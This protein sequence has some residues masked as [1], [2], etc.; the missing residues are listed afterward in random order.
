M[1]KIP[2]SRWQQATLA[3]KLIRDPR[4]PI[5]TKLAVPTAVAAYVIS[6]VDLIP[7]MLVGIGQVDDFTL[8]LLAIPAVSWFLRRFAPEVI[9]D[10]Y[11]K[12][13]FSRE[14]VTRPAARSN[15]EVVETRFRVIH[16]ED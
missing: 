5:W 15:P 16:D 2:L 3:Y 8:L 1:T 14:L 9:V 10:A 7:D 12:T 6:P 11:E 4:V 13:L